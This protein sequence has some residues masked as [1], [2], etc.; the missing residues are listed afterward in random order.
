[1]SKFA[2]TFEPINSL[3]TSSKM[4]IVGWMWALDAH[5]ESDRF[6][7]NFSSSLSLAECCSVKGD[8]FDVALS[9]IFQPT[10]CLFG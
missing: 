7:M 6:E 5:V 1:M 9:L 10:C 3:V 2:A 8:G 4:I